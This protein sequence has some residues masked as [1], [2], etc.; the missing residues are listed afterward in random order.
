MK[1]KLLGKSG[2]RVSEICLGT[3]TFGEEF[4]WGES[5]EES[6]KV[7]EAFLQAGGNF[8]DTANYYTKGTSE[9]F[10]G[11]FMAQDRERVVIATKYSLTTNPKDPNASGNHRKNMTQALN[12]SLKR[13]KTD[14]VDV[15]WVHAWDFL[16]PVEE[17]MRA[18]DDMVRAGKVLYIGISDTPAWIVSQANTLA[19]LRGWTP[20]VAL[21]L[22]YSLLERTIER[23][24]LP[25]AKSFDMAITAWSPLAMG[26]LTGKYQQNAPNDSRF[27]INQPWGT[28][29]LNEKNIEI[30]NIVVA[31]AKEIGKTPAQIAI[32]WLRQHKQTIIPIIGAK[33][34]EQLKDNLGCLDFELTDEQIARLNNASHIDLGFPHEFLKRDDLRKILYGETLD[35]ISN[36]HQR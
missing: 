14:Y 9:K 36:T 7:Y 22:E 26:V 5:K 28:L 6:R 32:N 19:T 25:L 24:F 16:T 17:V 2:L 4:G 33:H 3:M 31:I 12:A 21:Q 30:V 20:F 35:L 11:E 13:L 15:Y 10:L 1:Y 18:L 34:V 23:E 8:F 27:K 29:Y